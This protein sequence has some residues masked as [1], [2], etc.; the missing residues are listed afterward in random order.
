M[1]SMKFLNTKPNCSESALTKIIAIKEWKD[2]D[3]ICNIVFYLVFCQYVLDS[4][5][6][7]EISPRALMLLRRPH[8]SH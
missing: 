6:F 7:H 8:V 2:L 5:T 1:R 3:E 4:S